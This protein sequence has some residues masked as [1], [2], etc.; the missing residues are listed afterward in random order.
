MNG[1]S[2]VLCVVCVQLA[3][4][5][6]EGPLLA[7]LQ[8]EPAHARSMR[9]NLPALTARYGVMGERE[10]EGRESIITS[11]MRSKVASVTQ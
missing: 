10:R 3:S 9:S 11:L 4:V 8:V 1:A 7:M 2:C 5:I 6:L